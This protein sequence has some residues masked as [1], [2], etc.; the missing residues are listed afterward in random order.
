MSSRAPTDKDNLVAKA[1]N[2]RFSSDE[3]NFEVENKKIKI[4]SH[5][6]IIPT[7]KPGHLERDDRA[8]ITVQMRICD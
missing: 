2:T 7:Y 4:T 5:A 8:G 3:G 1:K 6:L